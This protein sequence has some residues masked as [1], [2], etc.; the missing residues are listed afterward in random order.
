MAFQIPEP[1]LA[2]VAHTKLRQFTSEAAVLEVSDML[3]ICEP[4]K[5]DTLLLALIRQSAMRCRDELTEM[6][7]RRILKTQAAGEAE[8]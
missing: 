7:L 5:R 2:D 6:M 1:L 8:T 3:R 4:G